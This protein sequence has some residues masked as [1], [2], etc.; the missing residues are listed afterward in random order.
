MQRSE[1]ASG[2]DLRDPRRA[3]RAS[4]SSAVTAMNALSRGLRAAMTA[5]ASSVRRSDRTAPLASWT[6]SSAIVGP[7]SLGVAGAEASAGRLSAGS[8]GGQR[9][10]RIRRAADGVVVP[11]SR[12]QRRRRLR[13]ALEQVCELRAACGGRRR[14]CRP[15]ATVQSSCAV[16]RNRD[17]VS[18]RE[19]HCEEPIVGAQPFIVGRNR[20]GVLRAPLAAARRSPE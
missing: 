18:D 19:D 10:R 14:T 2:G 4:A 7:A 17:A 11:V 3:R 20:S 13:E 12:A 6:D 1:I 8:V 9:L 16:D 15:R 5:S